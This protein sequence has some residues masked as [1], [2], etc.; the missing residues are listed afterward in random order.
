MPWPEFDGRIDLRGIPLQHADWSGEGET[1]Q[2]HSSAGHLPPSFNEIQIINA[3]LSFSDAHYVWFTRARFKN[4]RLIGAN[5]HSAKA[6]GCEYDKVDFIEC[7]LSDSSIGNPHRNVATHFRECLFQRTD[8]TGSA[9]N[10]AKYNFVSFDSCNLKDINFNG[11]SFENCCFI[12]TVDGVRFGA[13]SVQFGRSIWTT[14]M[15]RSASVDRL[16]LK[17][18]DFSKST[19]RSV[20]FDGV[21]LSTCKLPSDSD[22]IIVADQHHVFTQVRSEIER[23]WPHSSAQV[24]LRIID[25]VYLKQNPMPRMVLRPNKRSQPIDVVNRLDL[26]ET[27]GDVDGT[28][29]F[30]LIGS[31]SS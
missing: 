27:L 10:E 11:S 25:W 3:D 31:M 6:W 12:G 28:K 20:D 5:W 9:H 14:L 19:L 21:D 30:E 7:D 29:L 16:I 24:A 18:V 13:T 8:L 15:R 26:I 2:S 4:V 22:H 23:S 17:S 1:R